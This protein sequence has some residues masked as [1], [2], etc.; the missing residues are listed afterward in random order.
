MKLGNDNWKKI[1]AFARNCPQ[2]KVGS[3]RICRHFVEAVLDALEFDHAI[4]DCAYAA[5]HYIDWLIEQGIIPVLPPQDRVKLAREYDEWLYRE[6]HLVEC[7]VNKYKHYRRV[8]SRIDK[9]ASRYLGFLHFVGTRLVMLI[10]QRNLI[11]CTLTG[12]SQRRPQVLQRRV[13]AGA[14]QPDFLAL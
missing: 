5:R 10:C 2:M 6:R 3:S 11:N 4:A 14:H 1:Q 8:F 12:S 7:L 13:P 9:L